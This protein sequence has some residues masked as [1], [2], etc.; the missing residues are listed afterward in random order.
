MAC[1]RAVL[2]GRMPFSYLSPKH[3][4]LSL[5]MITG[6]VVDSVQ[7][8]TDHDEDIQYWQTL[9]LKFHDGDHWR[10]QGTVQSR[11]FDHANY[12][13]TYLFMPTVEYKLTNNWD[14]GGSYLYEGC[15]SDSGLDYLMLHIFWL[16][17]SPHWN[18][19]DNLK[20]SM[21]HVAAYRAVES[22]DNYWVS[23]HKFDLSYQLKDLGPF[24]GVGAN[25]E[26]FY[27]FETH[28]LCENRFVPLS[29]T[30]K[31]NSE[32]KLSL[33]AMIQSKDFSGG[34]D[35]WEHAYVFGQSLAVS[36]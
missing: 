21:R 3:F 34:D 6:L 29:L 26:L 4:L 16:H 18:L 15:R 36:F 14:V 13:G 32:M 1:V 30:F 9:G 7:A 2:L 5:L 24:V 11:L 28:N 23:R 27:N 22:S 10:V 35:D 19:T 25:T 20:F 33:Y 17:V 12:L 31:L 8:K